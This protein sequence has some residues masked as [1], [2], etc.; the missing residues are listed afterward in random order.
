M[1]VEFYWI[2]VVVTTILSAARLSRLLVIDKFPP[3][4]RVRLWYEDKTDGSDW[5][6]L[7]MC[8]FCMAPWVTLLVLAAGLLA[9][10]YDPSTHRSYDNLDY[11]AWW[12]FNG[13][14]AVSYL[15][16][17]YVARDGAVGEDD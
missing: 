12:L 15:A 5:Q 6:W 4:K 17:S 8:A 7:T 14:L 16:A 1:S 11:T 2:A 13:W 10:V 9:G 3:V